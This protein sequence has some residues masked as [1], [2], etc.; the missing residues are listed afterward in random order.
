MRILEKK[1]W[2]IALFALFAIFVASAAHGQ[3]V[4]AANRID[5]AFDD[6]RCVLYITNGNELVRYDNKNQTVLAPLP[7]GTD[8]KGIAVSPDYSMLAVADDATSGTDNMVFL[9]DLETNA[10][11]TLTF[12]RVGLESGT[13]SVAFAG[14]GQLLISSDFG[15]SGNVPLRLYDPASN[16]T[17]TVATIRQRSMLA[18]SADGSVVGFEESNSSGGP[19]GRYRTSD[20][21]VLA[22]PGTSAFNYEI[23]VARD[24]SQYAFP[25]FGGCD[26]YDG[27]FTFVTT[28]GSSSTDH[29][30][31]IV[32][33]PT[34]DLVYAAWSGTSDIHELDTATFTL[35][36]TYATGTA[37]NHPGNFGYVEGRLKISADGSKLFCTVDNGVQIITL[38][39]C[40][41][42]GIADSGMVDND[43]VLTV[44]TSPAAATSI[45]DNDVDC[46]MGAVLT[47][48][49]FDATSVLGATVSVNPDGTFTYNPG[50]SATLQGLGSGMSMDDSFTYT[51]SDGTDANVGTVT[52]TVNG[53]DPPSGLPVGG[54]LVL[55][56]L[57]IALVFCAFR[58][59]KRFH[60]TH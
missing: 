26:I 36:N 28:I 60:T 32:Y 21:N 51:V 10:V 22:G 15:G 34:M 33:H 45:L 16:T 4:A 53:T 52:I 9:V 47:V 7:L 14:D 48:T 55:L 6:L 38:G 40:Q 42:Q 56:A 54:S 43:Q 35:Q 39:N 8:L 50:P 13:F 1:R 25:T 2:S 29:P 46:D 49:A 27:S 59:R 12:T 41:P 5:M 18:A 23:G 30:I 58:E 44:L 57:S 37:F 19:F 31:G 20:G 24:G 11:T 17:T 3:F